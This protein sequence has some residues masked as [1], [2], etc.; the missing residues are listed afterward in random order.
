MIFC[1]K[2][3]LFLLHYFCVGPVKVNKTCYKAQQEMSTPD[4]RILEI[5]KREIGNNKSPEKNYIIVE[6]LEKG[7]PL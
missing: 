2:L 5:K 3:K 7:T 6:M 1:T 4:I